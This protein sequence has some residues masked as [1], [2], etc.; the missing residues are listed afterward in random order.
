MINH[1]AASL[2]AIETAETPKG[3]AGKKAGPETW[4]GWVWGDWRLSFERPL[5]MGIINIT[6]DSFSD[7]GDFANLDKALAEALRHVEEGADL[8][9]IGGESSRPGARP[10]SEAEELKRV[11]PLVRTLAARVKI[12]ISVD[13]YKAEVARRALDAG[14]A[15]INDI[16]AGR[17]EPAILKVAA[18]AKTP[19]IL[20]HMLGEPGT[21]QQN[22]FY[23][24]LTAEVREFLLT[25]AQNA[26][27]AGVNQDMIVLDP[28]LGFG[29]TAA[30][31]LTILNRL[32]EV[33][34][35]DYRVLIGLSRKNFLGRVTGRQEPKE[36]D[37][38]TAVANAI[39]AYKGANIIRVHRVAPTREAM[40]IISA[41][42][43]E[44][45]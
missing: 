4:S 31:N 30:H 43:S 23:R 44:S 20:M 25:A 36:R 41:I 3:E 27:E 15:L 11:I 6:P 42:R 16:Y 24:N 1:D 28:G 8:L 37:Q 29:K 33:M 2:T 40:R 9:D 35:R 34:P 22:P 39:A 38:A 32:E 18:A 19:L 10:L 13:T 26:L 14:A 5:I 17:R 45:V 7:G 12:P 21:M